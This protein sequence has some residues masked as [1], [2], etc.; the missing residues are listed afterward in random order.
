M[1]RYLVFCGEDYY[2]CRWDDYRGSFDTLEDA[3]DAAMMRHSDWYQIVD[4]DTESVVK[5]G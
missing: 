1:K 2:P 3:L 5:E 4:R